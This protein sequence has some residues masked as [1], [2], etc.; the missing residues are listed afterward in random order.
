MGMIIEYKNIHLN[1]Y[2][3]PLQAKRIV[4][5]LDDPSQPMDPTFLMA[6][7]IPASVGQLETDILEAVD[8]QKS[9]SKKI[10]AKIFALDS[11]DDFPQ[12]L[13]R[14]ELMRYMEGHVVASGQTWIERDSKVI[15][16]YQH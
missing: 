9:Q 1:W 6:Y 15:D 7:N 2:N 16:N 12:N 13:T 14:A 8:Q 5:I 3:Y 4:V 11:L 10:R